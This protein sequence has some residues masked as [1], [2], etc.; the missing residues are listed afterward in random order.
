VI[1]SGDMDLA[2]IIRPAIVIIM[3]DDE[4]QMNRAQIQQRIERIAEEIDS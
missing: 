1:T 2:C 4:A 3:D